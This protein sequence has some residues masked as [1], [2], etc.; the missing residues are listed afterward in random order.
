MC[1]SAKAPKVP[2]VKEPVDREAD[3]AKRAYGQV[4]ERQA[5]AFGEGD[6]DIVGSIVANDNTGKPAINTQLKK[7]MGASA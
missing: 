6:T 1:F 3:A 4:A 2:E 7:L 5:R